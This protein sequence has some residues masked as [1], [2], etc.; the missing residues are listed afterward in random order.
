MQQVL[1]SRQNTFYTQFK[2]PI[3]TSNM[4]CHATTTKILDMLTLSLVLVPKKHKQNTS[5][6]FPDILSA[7]KLQSL[8][9]LLM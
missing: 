5:R 4:N 6:P 1:F 2:I 8:G 3:K 9:I 7:A